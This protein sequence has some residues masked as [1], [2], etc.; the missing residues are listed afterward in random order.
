MKRALITGI[1]GQDGSYLADLLLEKGYFVHGL[2]RRSSSFNLSRLTHILE[3]DLQKDRL[4]LHYG[5]LT[6]SC[7][8]RQII[9]TVMPE[10]IYHL[11]AMSDVKV[12]FDLPEYTAMVDGLGTLRLL[13]AVRAEVPTARFY[14]ASTSELY[15]K[16]R[17][18]PQNEK[19]PF[20]PRSPY[21]VAKA[22][23][24]WTVVN[25][26]EAYGL[27]ASNGILFNHES[28]RRGSNFVTRKISMGVARIANG[29][30][31]RIILG[32]LNAKRDWGYAKDF[33]EGMWKILQHHEPE[34]FVLATGETTTVRRLVE[35]AFQ[36][37][38]IEIIWEG[39]DVE[40]RGKDR[41]T[42]KILVEVSSELFRPTEVDV[43]IGDS[44]KAKQKLGWTAKTQLADLVKLMV[45][46]DLKNVAGYAYA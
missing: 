6:D 38:G 8:L 39:R 3:D 27:Y 16:V 17:E 19:T 14:Q 2:I 35:L 42:G 40:E 21:G 37:V 20:Y 12:S 46:E 22:Y 24:F 26:R 15:G 41:L 1:S 10:E 44:S 11:G 36:E 25:Y 23:S 30:Q 28:P 32:N 29:S 7:S 43:L 45:A 4:L 5:D 33:V 13:E 31:E 34:E 9:S 18:T